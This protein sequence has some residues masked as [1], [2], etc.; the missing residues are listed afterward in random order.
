MKTI[1]CV[2]ISGSMTN[3]QLIKSRQE[4]IKRFKPL[5]VVVLFSY[6]YFIVYDLDR[7]FTSYK[8]H[9]FT[10]RGTNASKVLNFV[11]EQQANSILY[12]DGYLTNVDKF[13]EFVEFK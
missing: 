1:H 4:V 2:D 13:N 11:A 8:H 5:D 7:C 10:M 9:K 6:E 3:D 12:S